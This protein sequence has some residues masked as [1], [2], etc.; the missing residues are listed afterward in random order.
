[1]NVSKMNE[2]SDKPYQNTSIEKQSNHA[3]VALQPDL[4]Q[5]MTNIQIGMTT[6]VSKTLEDKISPSNNQPKSV[7]IDISQL[8][9]G[10]KRLS[11]GSSDDP[12][13]IK[14]N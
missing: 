8:N 14:D 3:S 2:D 10:E 5:N 11:R 4:T 7:K 1:M 6:G 13:L 9:T 12:I